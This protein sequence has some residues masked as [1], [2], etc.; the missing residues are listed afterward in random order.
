MTIDQGF[1]YA[2]LERPRYVEAD[3]RERGVL[4]TEMAR[5]S[6]LHGKTLIRRANGSLERK[7]R[8]KQRGRT[9]GPK[10]DGARRVIPEALDHV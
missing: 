9:Y 5:V 10:V 6:G 2:M 7:R 8:R 1:K 3:R 4:L